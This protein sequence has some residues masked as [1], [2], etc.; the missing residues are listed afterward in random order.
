MKPSQILVSVA[1]AVA[2]IG[3][4][5][6]VYAQTTTSDPANSSIVAPTNPATPPAIVA[7]RAPMAGDTSGRTTGTTD[8][9]TSTTNSTSMPGAT[10]GSGSTYRNPAAGTS[11]MSSTD[12]A[13]RSNTGASNARTHDADSR[14]AMTTERAPRADRN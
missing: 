3:S 12:G 5:G 8:S 11:A 9:A 14:R 4:A 6:I 7:P 2:A 1:A 10:T 13:G